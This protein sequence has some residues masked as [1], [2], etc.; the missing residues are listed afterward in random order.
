MVL[1]SLCVGKATLK[2]CGVGVTRVRRWGQ[3][4]SL[5]SYIGYDIRHHSVIGVVGYYGS[6]KIIQIDRYMS[7]TEAGPLECL[8]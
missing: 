5:I 4:Q 3:V 8:P 6:F 7:H 1:F 2:C